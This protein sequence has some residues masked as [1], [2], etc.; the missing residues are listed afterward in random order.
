[1]RHRPQEPDWP[2]RDRL[3]YSKGHSS[4]ALYASLARAGYFEHDR[5]STYRM[6]GGLEGHPDQWAVPGVEVT[7]GS[8]GQGLSMANGIALALRLNKSSARVYP[9]IS[10]GETQEGMTWEAALTAAHQKLDNLCGFLDYNRVQ[11]DGF[12]DEIKQLDP[13]PEKWRAF[14]W[15]VVEI[16]GHDM[17][18]I[19]DALEEMATITGKPQ[20]IVAN[21]IKGKGVSFMEHNPTFHGTAPN[22]EQFAIAMKELG[23]TD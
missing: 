17:G 3:V 14:G 12:V 22:D 2:D 11:L 19:I 7:T 21:T 1:M 16:D 23:A 13:L 5:L 6:L 20:M 4:P 10:D 8:L 18:Q 9:V 15:H